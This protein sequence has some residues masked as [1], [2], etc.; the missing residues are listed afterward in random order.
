MHGGLL[1]IRGNEEHEKSCADHGI[2]KIDLLVVNLYPFQA[3]AAPSPRPARCLAIA[4]C[5]A[6]PLPPP[7]STVA[8]G[9]DFDNCVENIDIGAL[10]LL[11]SPPPFSRAY[12]IEWPALH[13]ASP[14]RDG[15]ALHRKLPH[16]A[17]VPSTAGAGVAARA[18]NGAR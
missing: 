11:S 18:R 6:C 8:K 4:E 12:R 17:A 2:D 14:R 10:P 16:P 15:I 1:S 7:Q 5:D 9:A 3:R 13:I